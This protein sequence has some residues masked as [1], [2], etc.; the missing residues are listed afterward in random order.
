[1]SLTAEFVETSDSIYKNEEI[2]E[3]ITI[4]VK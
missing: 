1:M 3:Y 2:F 4:K